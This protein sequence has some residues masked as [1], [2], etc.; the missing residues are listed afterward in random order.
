[1]RGA[2]EIVEANLTPD[3]YGI[4]NWMPIKVAL[5]FIFARVHF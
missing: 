5:A 2:D 3:A 4:V 1:L